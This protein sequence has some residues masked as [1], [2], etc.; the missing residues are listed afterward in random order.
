MERGVTQVDLQRLLNEQGLPLH[1][2]TINKYELGDRDP[3]PEFIYN[4]V[5]CLQLSIDEG[6][7]LIHARIADMTKEFMDS[8]LTLLE[9]Q[10]K[11]RP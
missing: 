10:R 7:A 6:S 1:L 8:Y 2:S 5:K 11:E 9:G 4:V 3:T